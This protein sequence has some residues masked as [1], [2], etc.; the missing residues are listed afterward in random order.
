MQTYFSEETPKDNVFTLAF[1]NLENLFD[2]Y[3]D[4]AT[5]DDEFTPTGEK[6][7]NY[8]RYRNKI[9]NL[10]DVI[11]N[12]GQTHSA[13][14]PVIVGVAEVENEN[15]VRDLVQSK[16]LSAH[17]YD[18]VHYDSPDHRGIDV[19]LLYRK[20]RFEV[21]KSCVHPVV[22]YQQNGIRDYTR[23]ILHVTGELN[24]E[25]M[26]VLV[27]HWPSRTE[28]IRETK[29]KRMT[30]SE[31]CYFLVSKIQS[32]SQNR[33]YLFDQIIFTKNFYDRIPQK[34][35]LKYTEVY[36]V[37]FIKTWKGKRKDTPFRTYIGRW[38]QGGYSDHFPVCSYLMLEE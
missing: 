16:A 20:D 10:S 28:G 12:I 1:Y 5:N 3:D 13:Y 38:H 14:T 29:Y 18:Y 32:Y 19:A 24:G 36:D 35:R 34:H 26:H 4:P 15:V 37:R 9:N 17:H 11:V 31:T 27:N 22:I 25:R 21:L 33:W 23:D 2:I 7:W 6:K 8:D 30:A